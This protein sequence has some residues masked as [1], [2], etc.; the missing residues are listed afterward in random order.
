MESLCQIFA[1]KE[2]VLQICFQ[3]FVLHPFNIRQG[4]ASVIVGC[5]YFVFLSVWSFAL[6]TP[7]LINDDDDDQNL[8]I[9][10]V[11]FASE[12]LGD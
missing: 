12:S 10:K 9:G 11:V 8:N 3:E 5:L 1:G 2:I 7:T 4:R 6:L